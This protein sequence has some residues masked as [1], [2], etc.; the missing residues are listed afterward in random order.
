MEEMIR[1]HDN[2][3]HKCFMGRACDAPPNDRHCGVMVKFGGEPHPARR[4][5]RER[6]CAF[7]GDTATGIKFLPP[8]QV[9]A[10]LNMVF[11]PTTVSVS[12]TVVRTYGDDNR[13]TQKGAG[14]L[15]T[16]DDDI[17]MMVIN[18]LFTGS[19]KTLT[20][21]LGAIIFA[22]KRR[23]EIAGRL[24]FLV[25]EQSTAN[26][27]ARV[28]CRVSDAAAR[29]VNSTP[30]YA[31]VVVVMCAKHLFSQW[32]SACAS[33]LHILGMEGVAVLEN[34]LPGSAGLD[35]RGE[36]DNRLKIVLL[37]SS[38]NLL[39]LNLEF[40]PVL[41]VDEFTIK[42]ASNVLTR[43]SDLLPLMG[44]LLMV[45]ADAGS[46]ERIIF[47]SHRRSFLRKMISWDDINYHGDVHIAMVAGIPLISASVLPTLERYMVGEFM[48]DQLKKVRYEKFTVRYT[49]SFASRLFGSNFEMS[50]MSGS[51]LIKDKFGIELKGTKT[52]RNVLAQ[53]NGAI[54]HMGATDGG[55]R[56][57]PP[58]IQLRDKLMNFVG[59]ME[60]CPICLEEYE[61][62]SGA[63][64]I[65]PCWHIVCDKCLRHLMAAHHSRCPMCRV[66]IEGHTTALV[67]DGGATVGK[68]EE[69]EEEVP[70]TTTAPRPDKTLLANFDAVLR[71]TA[72][73]DKACVD[74][75]RCLRADV[76]SQ[77]YKIVMIVPDEHFFTKFAVDVRE[78]MD[79]S[80]VQIIEFKTA[81]T[82]RKHVTGKT[83]TSQIE[84]FASDGGPPTKILFTTEGKTDSLTGLD[85]PRVDCII[86]LGNG[87]SLQRLGR[88]TR[89]PRMMDEA[90]ARKTVRYICLEPV[91]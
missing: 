86:S 9:E 51:R 67:D 72:G 35:C 84:S 30:K 7:K 61:M 48:I 66:G 4:G 41:V 54:E 56:T 12:R 40:V 42:S 14:A 68:G 57:L 79:E 17:G 3:I 78:V 85:F 81:G 75:L 70:E 53:V 76:G 63:S 47:G 65:N 91:S 49:P 6:L 25:R 45:S 89:L 5:V 22:D 10:V 36:A 27:A 64:L 18:D 39:R 29:A 58:L 43:A 60:A 46:V 20:T 77:P 11:R 16:P 13:I 2:G 73:L 31:N 38:A 52:I 34:P 83:V 32:K 26:W 8:F 88:L 21:I 82:K 37:H 44:R 69:A 28:Q 24:P 50:A 80:E 19:G 1:S 55:S 62:T 87:N 33:A 71:T 59:E 90:I 74:T 15:Q 23:R